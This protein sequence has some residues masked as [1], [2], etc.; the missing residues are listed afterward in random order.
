MVFEFA[1]SS[2]A[3]NASAA[4]RQQQPLRYFCATMLVPDGVPMAITS[5]GFSVITFDAYD[6]FSAPANCGRR[7]ALS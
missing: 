5:S 7:A 2:S 4:M 1:A 6:L 3:A